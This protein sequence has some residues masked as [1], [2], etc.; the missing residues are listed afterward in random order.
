MG[1]EGGEFIHEGECTTEE[2]GPVKPVNE[3]PVL[4]F[5]AEQTEA[6]VQAMEEIATGTP[7]KIGFFDGVWNTIRSWFS[8]LI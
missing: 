7:E 8:W 2:S 5:P 3:K 1:N 4:T 6:A